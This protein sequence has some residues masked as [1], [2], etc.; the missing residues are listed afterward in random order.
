MINGNILLFPSTGKWYE[1]VICF[2]T[3]GPFCHVE[4][5]LNNT[6]MIGAR[7]DGIAVHPLPSDPESYVAIDILPYVE[8]EASIGQGLVWAIEQ[9]GR[10]Y[11]WG[12][13]LC[14]GLKFLFPN[15]PFRFGFVDHYDCSD[16]VV[17]YLQQAGVL[18]P[19][20]FADPYADTPND[21]ARIFG[22]LPPRKIAHADNIPIPKRARGKR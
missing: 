2:A 9:R 12:D 22:I 21:I 20:A 8:N 13:I 6:S 11:G 5:A 15:N 7:V 1:R 10:R 17:R 4:I 14:A 19:E 3:H 18:L 16:F